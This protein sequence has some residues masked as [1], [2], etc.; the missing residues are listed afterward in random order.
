MRS[1]GESGGFRKRLF[2][3]LLRSSRLDDAVRHDPRTAGCGCGAAGPSCL[4]APHLRLIPCNQNRY[5]IPSDVF[6][7]LKSLEV[8]LDVRWPCWTPSVMPVASVNA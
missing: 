7:S 4:F 5:W 6:V 8:T 1:G 2:S 3:P